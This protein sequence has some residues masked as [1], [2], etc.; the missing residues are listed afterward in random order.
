L[1]LGKCRAPLGDPGKRF[2]WAPGRSIQGFSN[3]ISIADQPGVFLL[4]TGNGFISIQNTFSP[5]SP[6]IRRMPPGI[7]PYL[8][9]GYTDPGGLS[10]LFRISIVG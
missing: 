2:L 8:S 9:Y 7:A 4:D 10:G 1:V 3:P 6:Y 5:P